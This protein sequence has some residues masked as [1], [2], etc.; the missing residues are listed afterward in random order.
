MGRSYVNGSSALQSASCKD[1]LVSSE[2]LA[3]CAIPK[4]RRVFR[5]KCEE[6]DAARR[7]PSHVP[8]DSCDEIRLESG[9]A[10]MCNEERCKKLPGCQ[11]WFEHLD[12]TDLGPSRLCCGSHDVF[13]GHPFSQKAQCQELFHSC[14][15]A[16]F[17]LRWGEPICVPIQQQCPKAPDPDEGKFKLCCGQQGPN[18]DG[19]IFPTWRPALQRTCEYHKRDR[20]QDDVARCVPASEKCQ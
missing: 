13:N 16:D 5:Q 3:M 8:L 10:G 4:C 12:G 9:N 7:A 6:F 18:G 2:I 20:C 14:R 17:S 19:D 1:M 15:A 11:R